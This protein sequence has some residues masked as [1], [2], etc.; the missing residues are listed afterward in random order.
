MV[1]MNIL[2]EF[3]EDSLP[4]L[5]TTGVTWGAYY[6]FS[7]V[8]QLH[9]SDLNHI[10]YAPRIC[11]FQQ[12]S[13]AWGTEFPFAIV[14][15]DI[16]PSSTP[17]HSLYDPYTKGV[18]R[19][20]KTWKLKKIWNVITG[21]W[22]MDS[23]IHAA[24]ESNVPMHI[25]DQNNTRVY[26]QDFPECK[27]YKLLKQVSN[28]TEPT[29]DPMLK[30]ILDNILQS[31]VV[32]GYKRVENMLKVGSPVLFCGKITRELDGMKSILRI[33]KPQSPFTYQCSG[34]SY[35]EFLNN[36][37]LNVNLLKILKKWLGIG[38]AILVTYCIVRCCRI[39][40][41]HLAAPTEEAEFVLDLPLEGT[42]TMDAGTPAVQGS[43]VC[44]ICYERPVQLLVKSCN[45]ACLCLTCAPKV[46]GLCPICRAQITS[47]E[48]IYFP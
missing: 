11:D 2:K 8:L 10:Q 26:V 21:T 39:V 28:F 38:L 42:E 48:K 22:D 43:L 7:K 44:S 34:L 30:K 20:L 27:Q 5:L 14:E 16:H 41:E 9:Q 3:I 33:S 13:A 37:I 19:D 4:F 32:V 18:V 46:K 6:I 12:L 31:E 45:H 40:Y 47:F 1:S 35:E 24:Y 17:I 36:K 23:S 29:D 15:G 25:V